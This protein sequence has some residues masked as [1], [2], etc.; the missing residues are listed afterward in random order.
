ML[1]SLNLHLHTSAKDI[2]DPPT[3]A[4]SR[5]SCGTQPCWATSVVHQHHLRQVLQRQ[6]RPMCGALY[7]MSIYASAQLHQDNLP[8]STTKPEMDFEEHTS[9]TR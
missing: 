7:N 5:S 3:T 1:I 9:E 2:D 8:T 6:G 4:L